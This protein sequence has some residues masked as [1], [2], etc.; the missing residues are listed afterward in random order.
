[1]NLA[2]ERTCAYCGMVMPPEDEICPSCGAPNPAYRPG[3]E[4]GTRQPRT[5]EE[6]RSFCE[7]KGMPLERMRFFMG[8]S[9]R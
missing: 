7:A 5:I 1:M 9:F 3:G 8:S 2:N 4:G 6:L